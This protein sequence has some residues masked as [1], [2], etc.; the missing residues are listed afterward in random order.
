MKMLLIEFI[1][2]CASYEIEYAE[3]FGKLTRQAVPDLKKL[4]I[5]YAAQGERQKNLAHVFGVSYV[6]HL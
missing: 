3:A 2:A 1:L 5:W 4:A 6:I